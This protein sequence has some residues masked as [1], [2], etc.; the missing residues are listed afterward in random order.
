MILFLPRFQTHQI[1]IL[2]L[3]ASLCIGELTITPLV[4]VLTALAVA[5]ALLSL[6]GEYNQSK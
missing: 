6:W 4:D 3:V 5:I 1:N 2:G